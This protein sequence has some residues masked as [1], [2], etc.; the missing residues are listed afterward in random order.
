MAAQPVALTA[1]RRHLTAP[2]ASGALGAL[3][4]SSSP[5]DE[6]LTRYLVEISRYPL[7][8][9]AEE[10]E[11]GRRAQVGDTSA[12]DRLIVCNLRLVVTI[13]K[14]YH[15][16]ELTLLDLIQEGT[17]GLIRAVEKYNP[18]A[19][20]RFA[21][22]A[23]WWIHKAIGKAI[24]ER[25]HAIPLP[26][27]AFYDQRRVR[28]AVD[29]LTF[30]LGRTPTAEETAKVTAL[31]QRRVRQL[32]ALPPRQVASLDA[33]LSPEGSSS[34]K[35]LT[36]GDSLTSDADG[37]SME[38][39]AEARDEQAQLYELL[40]AHLEPRE[41]AVV[42]L[43]Y[44]LGNAA[45]QDGRDDTK[46]LAHQHVARKLGISSEL[47]RLIEIEALTKLRAALSLTA[48]GVMS[49]I[50]QPPARKSTVKPKA[51][52]ATLLLS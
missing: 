24:M 3:P 38:D 4:M 40:R 14:R 16:R 25:D 33:P 42:V 30:M 23:S 41:L 18:R 48:D 2:R 7:L 35:P 22:Y 50:Q 12:R 51:K 6:L 47:A 19:S 13:A 45:T 29:Q 37:A 1:H 46:P 52:A 34:G 20:A 32:T 11:L 31:S 27:D 17:I 9:V 39:R 44:R 10:L 26:E 5:R 15:A 49:R 21:T 36:L 28:R 43:R 8:S